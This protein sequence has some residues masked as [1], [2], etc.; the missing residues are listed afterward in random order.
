MALM[1]R[2]RNTVSPK[3]DGCVQPDG[4]GGPGSS[5]SVRKGMTRPFRVA[6]TE[7]G[8]TYASLL[9]LTMGVVEMYKYTVLAHS[10]Q[11]E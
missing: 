6:S 11:R 7:K 4:Q 10:V 5:C 1:K 2:E 9:S 8:V 3:Q